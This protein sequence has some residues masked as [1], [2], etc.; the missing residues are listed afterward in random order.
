MSGTCLGVDIGGT[1]TRVGLVSAAHRVL[2]VREAPTP[3]QDGARA[4]L[5][6]VAKLGRE[7][8]R[9]STDVAA[10]GVGTAGV[11]DPASGT[12][13]AATDALGG[14]AG[15]PV[16]RELAAL[17]SLPVYVDNDVNAFALGEAAAGAVAGQA[18]VL[19]VAVGT[20]I[21][22]AFLLHGRVW[23]GA[24]HN[25]GEIGH[26]PLPGFGH[27]PCPCGASGHLESVAAGPAMAARYHELSG[28]GV[29]F[30]DVARRADGDDRL[31]A[32]VVDEGGRVLGQLLA[33]LANAIDPESVVVG[34]GVA[35]PAGRYWSAA[36]R[37]YREHLL[38]AAREV[39]LLPA[40]LGK[41][42]VLVGAAELARRG[43]S[44]R[45]P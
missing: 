41:D 15:T 23:R 37:H 28:E 26:I 4:V 33:G 18:H 40:L 8:C 7:L 34:G 16:A 30:A 17:G 36:E 29:T 13:V 12:I 19:A 39:P 42:A 3:A 27:R 9:E 25:A 6:V 24:H 11:V 31:A 20:G 5:Q 1:K 32:E 45:T 22:G 10:W 44:E 35:Q 14:W 38:P 43:I 21:G 2:D